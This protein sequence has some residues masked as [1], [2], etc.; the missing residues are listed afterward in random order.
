M[1]KTKNLTLSLSKEI[2]NLWIVTDVQPCPSSLKKFPQYFEEDLDNDIAKLTTFGAVTLVLDTLAGE[3][4]KMDVEILMADEHTDYPAS[5]EFE[6][7]D[8]GVM[9]AKYYV[10]NCPGHPRLI[11][12]M[13][14][15]AKKIIRGFPA[16]A[17][18]R[19]AQ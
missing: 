17:Y 13:N 18:V 4:K 5:V 12:W 16:F 11:A 8:P 15:S 9:A 3:E 7:A 14:V 10:N 19:R 1:Q 6:L 2:G